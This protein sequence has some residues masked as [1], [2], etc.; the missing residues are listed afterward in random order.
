M[1][2]NRYLNPLKPLDTSMFDTLFLCSSSIR[3]KLLTDAQIPFICIPHT[4][5]ETSIPFTESLDTFVRQIAEKKLE[6][7]DPNNI[8]KIPH[9]AL[10]L[11]SADTLVQGTISKKIYGK[12]ENK[13]D[14]HQIITEISQE[15]L[16]VIT[17][18]ALARYQ[19][20]NQKWIKTDKKVFS[21]GAAI[22]F[23]IPQEEIELYLK[24]S[25]HALYAAGATT[26]E[27]Y[28]ALYLQSI[29][30]SYTA[31]MGLPLFELKEEL[32]KLNFRF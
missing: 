22:S 32:K 12:P 30:G 5:D 29:Q 25:P 2:K 10:F 13:A 3:Q 11:L 9:E 6:S 31:V 24:R 7:I 26:I 4:A 21:V 28:G 23:T 27:N 20:Q 19:K 17:G 18:C 15:P 8:K 1:Q 16:T 14:A